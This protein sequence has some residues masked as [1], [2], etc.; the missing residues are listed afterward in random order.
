MD[1][2][3]P[4]RG[5]KPKI[6]EK[7]EKP[8]ELIVE[9]QEKPNENEELLISEEPKKRGRRPKD[10][11]TLTQ[12]KEPSEET[13]EN[14]I[15]H[16]PN[17]TSKNLENLNQ[18]VNEPAPYSGQV[19]YFNFEDLSI[20]N[21]NVLDEKT[22]EIVDL[23]NETEETLPNQNNIT[24]E[25][26]N[27]WK[28][29]PI[30]SNEIFERIRERRLLEEQNQ[31]PTKNSKTTEKCLIQF[32]ETNKT[33][34]WPSNTSVACWYEGHQFEGPPCTLPI[35]YKN[36]CFKCKGVFCSPECAAAFNFRE[37]N[38][39]GDKW[40]QYS[41]LVSLYRRVYNKPSLR[42][43]LASSKFVLNTYGGN[44]SIKEFR[45]NN[46][47]PDKTYKIVMPPMISILPVSQLVEVDK[48]FTSKQDKKNY[49]IDKSSSQDNNGLVLK[50][51]RP[52]KYTENTLDKCMNL[53]VDQD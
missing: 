26:L 15:L 40:E 23:L 18:N 35:E 53:S 12:T 38:D 1:N 42:I 39:G 32:E 41:L 51:S 46:S 25:N 47:N 21:Q 43:K 34:T 11:I 2:V 50:R 14:I 20:N 45:A 16:I 9:N 10:K 6:T 13:S 30:H 37:D 27:G 29:D 36:G 49:V 22:R 3:K 31:L 19:E 33:Q 4:R 28:L 48:G 8:I 17:I 5:R 24:L 44:I 7:E 52:F